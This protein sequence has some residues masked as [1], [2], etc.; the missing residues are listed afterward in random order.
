MDEKSRNEFDLFIRKVISGEAEIAEIYGLELYL[1][2]E[3]E[4]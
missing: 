2:Y 4:P 3:Y 1:Q